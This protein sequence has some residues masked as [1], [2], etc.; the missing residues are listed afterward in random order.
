MKKNFYRILAL[1]LAMLFCF[2]A[3]QSRYSEEPNSP[4]GPDMPNGG[5]TI[6]EV[7]T[8]QPRPVLPPENIPDMKPEIESNAGEDLAGYTKDQLV[9]KWGY[10]FGELYG[11]NGYAWLME[12]GLDYALA[13]FDDDDYVTKMSFFHVM[14]ATVQEVSDEHVSLTPLPD[15]EEAEQ[16]SSFSLPIATFGQKTQEKLEEGL[17]VYISYDGI[18]T[19]AGSLGEVF[20]AEATSPLSQFARF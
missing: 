6:E 17:T 13:Y 12:N 4:Q 3:C 19:E 11:D 2:T 5:E 8:S 18:I 14:K 16:L 1:S 15:M 9:E 7:A 20:R 10:P